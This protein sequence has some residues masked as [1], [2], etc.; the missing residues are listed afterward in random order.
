MGTVTINWGA[1]ASKSMVSIGSGAVNLVSLYYNAT[2]PYK[3]VQNATGTFI[4]SAN[5]HASYAPGYGVDYAVIAEVDEPNLGP[6][7]V[8]F[9]IGGKGSQAACLML[10][11]YQLFSLWPVGQDAIIKWQDQNGNNNPDL[12]DQYTLIESVS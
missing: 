12:G 10:Q 1:I 7:L 2:L 3:F 11:N 8:A 4:Y 5:S 6:V 9:G